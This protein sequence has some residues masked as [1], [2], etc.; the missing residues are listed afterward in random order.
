MS[1][2]SLRVEGLTAFSRA[3]PCCSL[4]TFQQPEMRNGNAI[5]SLRAQSGMVFAGRSEAISC[6]GGDCFVAKDA[7]R[8][9]CTHRQVRCDAC[10]V[11]ALPAT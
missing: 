2:V 10:I 4:V 11:V 6:M 1:D 9:T 5:L 8:N 7:P 3:I